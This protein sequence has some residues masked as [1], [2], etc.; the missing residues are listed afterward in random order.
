MQESEIHVKRKHHAANH[1]FHNTVSSITE[2]VIANNYNHSMKPIEPILAPKSRPDDVETKQSHTNDAGS[3]KPTAEAKE[4]KPVAVHHVIEEQAIYSS[5][6]S[7]NLQN[8]KFKHSI[9]NK[10]MDLQ[11][12]DLDQ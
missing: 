9:D 8:Y 4:R 12:I 6:E 5:M 2:S 1:N 7:M 11:G 3:R 10:D